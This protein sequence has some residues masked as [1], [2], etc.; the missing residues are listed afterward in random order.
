M[1]FN[2]DDSIRENAVKVILGIAVFTLPLALTITFT[3]SS[4]KMNNQAT[5]Y[6][7]QAIKLNKQV[8]NN[9][10]KV[11]QRALNAPQTQAK[12]TK[13]VQEL[14]DV[15]QDLMKTNHDYNNNL[16]KMKNLVSSL[17]IL[18]NP[19]S[20]VIIDNSR[21]D[22]LKITSAIQPSFTLKDDAVTVDLLY[23]NT[24]GQYKG[25]LI[26]LIKAKYNILTNKFTSFDT[27]TTYYT[28]LYIQTGLSMQQKKEGK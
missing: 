18:Q 14:V 20:G 5:L 3:H 23:T 8:I 19:H 17:S 10:K 21:V 2:L 13:N 24:K 26:Y 1:K 7:S 9:R 25:K 27:H 22:H 16:L 28:P 15:Q 11:K 4:A 6:K 12:I